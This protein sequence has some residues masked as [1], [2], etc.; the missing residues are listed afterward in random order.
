MATQKTF[1]VWGDYGYVT[2]QLLATYTNERE[3]IA[4]AVQAAYPDCGGFDVIEV[5]YFA[6]DGEYVTVHT[7]QKDD[8][9]DEDEFVLDEC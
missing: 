7:I 5:A 8:M 9:V 3:A 1:E 2:E 6:P 4:Y